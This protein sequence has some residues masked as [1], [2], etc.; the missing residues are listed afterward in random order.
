MVDEDEY[1]ALVERRRNEDDFVVDD[2]ENS[3][4]PLHMPVSIFTLCY[5]RRTWIP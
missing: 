5:N 2:S 3:A 1:E 4:A